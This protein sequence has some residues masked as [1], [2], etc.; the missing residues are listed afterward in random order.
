MRFHR[1]RPRQDAGG[2]LV[3][4]LLV[5]MMLAGAGAAV[6]S[7]SLYRQSAARAI[8]E[9]ERAMITALAGLDVALFELREATD[10][11]GDEVGNAEGELD[12]GRYLVTIDPPFVGAGEYRLL[13]S[14]SYGVVSQGLELVVTSE[15]MF[16]V[17]MFGRDGVAVGGAYSI[18]SYDASAGTY[19]SQVFGGHAGDD[20]DVGSNRDIDASGGT[21]H[22][23]ARPGPG[24]QV[25]GRPESVMGSTAPM[26]QEQTFTP[27]VYS[28]TVP[29]SGVISGTL[30]LGPGVHRFDSISL[31]GSDDL[32]I[33]GDVVLQVDGD[34]SIGGTARVFVEPGA[35]LVIE[36]GSGDIDVRGTGIVNGN[37]LPASVTLLSA[38]ADDVSLRGT[39]DFFGMI[40]VPEAE[41][42]ARGNASFFGAVVAASVHVQGSGMFHFDESLEMP[43]SSSRFRVTAAWKTKAAEL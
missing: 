11:G 34:F 18:D 12:G 8:H 20:G 13:A 43:S 29:S 9:R 23:D 19:A 26:D 35:S 37:E 28:P 10:L 21:V 32:T 33:T 16:T 31:D 25:L 38:T 42:E 41:F 1:P 36:H 40:Y 5:A 17:G 7:T 14:G 24:G 39:A 3:P 22:G 27:F 2:V 6:V 15:S 4:V 30:T